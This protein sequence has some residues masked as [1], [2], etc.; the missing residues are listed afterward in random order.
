VV[1]QIPWLEALAKDAGTGKI[2]ILGDMNAWRDE[3]P[4]RQ[5]ADSGFV[6]LVEL[7]SGLPQHS[8]LYWGQTGTLDYAFATP[9]LVN[10]VKAAMIWN[11]NANWP[12]GMELPLPWLRAS[13]HDPVIVDLDFSQAATSN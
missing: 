4:I 9:A 10:N 8:F 6:D 3:D 1:A 7:H 12:A 2:L 13:D 11:V 5:F